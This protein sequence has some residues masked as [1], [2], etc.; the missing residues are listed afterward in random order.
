MADTSQA[1]VSDTFA[2]TEF[3]SHIN[4]RKDALPGICAAV[5]GTEHMEKGGTHALGEVGAMGAEA[6]IA[7][8]GGTSPELEHLRAAAC[9]GLSQ[10]LEVLVPDDLRRLARHSVFVRRPSCNEVCKKDA[11][12]RKS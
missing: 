4:A 12:Y 11:L 7:M 10:A 3:A 6:D 1:S 9:V 8:S 2:S 5:P